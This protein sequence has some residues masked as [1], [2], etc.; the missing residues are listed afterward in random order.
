MNQAQEIRVLAIDP[1]HRGFGFAVL[2]GP[3]SL[4]DWGV[5]MARQDKQAECLRKV[6]SL[7]EQYRPMAVV[8][9]DCAVRGS[10]R[11]PRVRRLVERIRTVALSAGVSVRL[12]SRVQVRRAF[13]PTSTKHVIACAV[14]ERFSELAPLLPPR[15]KPWMPEHYNSAIFDALALGLTFLHRENNPL[16]GLRVLLRKGA[17]IR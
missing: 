8:L 13:A 6:R 12:V 16:R 2:E 5:R 10:R 3:D 17:D 7:L 15:R 1:T 11:C 9:E 4:I 14:A